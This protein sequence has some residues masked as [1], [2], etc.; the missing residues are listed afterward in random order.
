MSLVVEELCNEDM[1]L[2]AQGTDDERRLH[3]SAK[4]AVQFDH[5]AYFELVGKLIGVALSGRSHL[6]AN[7]STPLLKELIR[8]PLAVDDLCGID[9]QLHRNVVQYHRGL[10]ESELADQGLNFTYQEERFG[11]VEVVDLLG[12]GGEDE[13]VETH[14][15]LEKYL[16][17]LSHYMMVRRVDKQMIALRQ[18]LGSLVPDVLLAAAGK[19]FSAKEFGVLISGTDVFDDEMLNDL[20]RYTRY[21]GYEASDAVIISFWSIIRRRFNQKQLPHS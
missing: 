11:Q 21:A 7:F 19:C 2:F 8:I 4:S 18:G 5:L 14:R 16:K 20:Q 13:T 15:D 12:C 6:P 17:A 1:G 3:P 10:A 9:A